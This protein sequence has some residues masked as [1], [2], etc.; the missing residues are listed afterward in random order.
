MFPVHSMKTRM[1]SRGIAPLIHRIGGER[2]T[3]RQKTP[4]PAK[5]NDGT[6]RTGEWVGPRVGLDDVEKR[7]ASE[8]R[9]YLQGV[10]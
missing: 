6:H 7:K 10:N 9:L 3:S 2:S 5:K 4:D 1:R 8:I